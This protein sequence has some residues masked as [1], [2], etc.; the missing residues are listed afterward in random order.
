MLLYHQKSNS[1]V[2]VLYSETGEILIKISI[3]FVT[4]RNCWMNFIHSTHDICAHIGIPSNV[5]IF[6]HILYL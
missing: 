4:R 2:Y 1:Y 3:I 5:S 6:T